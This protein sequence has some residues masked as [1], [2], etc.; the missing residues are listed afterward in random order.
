MNFSFSLIFGFCNEKR[1]LNLCV[2]QIKIRSYKPYRLTVNQQLILYRYRSATNTLADTFGEQ[3]FCNH[4]LRFPLNS[5]NYLN[6][7]N[8]NWVSELQTIALLFSTFVLLSTFV[9]LS[10][11][12]VLNWQC[13]LLHV[14]VTTIFSLYYILCNRHIHTL[15]T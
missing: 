15:C 7:F 14:T 8:N 3:T 13:R 2:K 6:N 5:L 4:S 12:A 9:M 1:W 11:A 10:I